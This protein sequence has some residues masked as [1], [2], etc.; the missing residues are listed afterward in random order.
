MKKSQ[1][2]AI[3]VAIA[4]TG[5]SGCATPQ[6]L[7]AVP[8]ASLPE[9]SAAQGPVRFLVARESQSFAA[10]ARNA[11]AGARPVQP[12]EDVT[13]RSIVIRATPAA[14][15]QRFD[16]TEINPTSTAN[17]TTRE[18]AIPDSGSIPIFVAERLDS[19]Y[20]PPIEV[21]E[22]LPPSIAD[23]SGKQTLPRGTGLIPKVERP[24]KSYA[25]TI[26][27][28]LIVLILVT[29]AFLAGRY[30]KF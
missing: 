16:E 11:L 27:A 9:A 2:L 13:S 20:L 8:Y 15:A 21:S 26:A 28:L 23:D 17:D 1:K 30:L 12:L 6:R 4:L 7:P 14:G 19:R 22:E 10:E 25:G 24:R 29:A 3:A 5:V 18:A